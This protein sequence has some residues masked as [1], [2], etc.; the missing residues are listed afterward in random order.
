MSTIEATENL[1]GA[2]ENSILQYLRNYPDAFITEMEITSHADG[3]TRFM[4]DKHWAHNPLTQLLELRL[5][6]TD[7]SGRYQIHAS[8]PKPTGLKIK[9]LAPQLRDILEH[10]D[11]KFDLSNFA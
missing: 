2:D 1:L 6:D 11:H 7:G 8:A 3:R 4:E 10:S 9:F 5:V